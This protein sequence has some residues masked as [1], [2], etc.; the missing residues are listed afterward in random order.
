MSEQTTT[1]N[2][3]ADEIERLAA[4]AETE[5]AAPLEGDYQEAE[6]PEMNTGELC[7]ALLSLGFGLVAARKGQHWALS[8][9]EATDTGQAVGAVLDKYFPDMSGAGPE[10]MAVLCLG[11]ITIPRLMLDSK[12]EEQRQ[13]QEAKQKQTQEPPA[14]HRPPAEKQD[15][16]RLDL[17]AL[18]GD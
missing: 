13:A 1:E 10:L 4:I 16:P 14:R 18:D 8:E 2:S 7:T 17:G 11:T 5:D 6:Q 15:A 12:I 9:G 3:Q